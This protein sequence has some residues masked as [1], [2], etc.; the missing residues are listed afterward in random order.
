MAPPPQ[1]AYWYSVIAV[2]LVWYDNLVDIKK[3][4]V[5]LE[6]LVKQTLIWWDPDLF[7]GSEFNVIDKD[8]LIKNTHCESYLRKNY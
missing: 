2:L 4:G 7:G 5:K 8:N 6:V 1:H 3:G